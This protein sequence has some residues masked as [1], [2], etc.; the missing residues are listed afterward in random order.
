MLLLLLVCVDTR[1]MDFHGG[2]WT[3]DIDAHTCPAPDPYDCELPPR[4]D[5]CGSHSSKKKRV[6]CVATAIAIAIV[7]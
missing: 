7:H 2:Q 6:T 1:E 5:F 3:A 4:Q